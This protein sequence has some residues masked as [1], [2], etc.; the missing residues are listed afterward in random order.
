MVV[1][2]EICSSRKNI[3]D[4]LKLRDYDVDKYSNFTVNE[5]EIL[6]ENEQLDIEACQIKNPTQKVIVKYLWKQTKIKTPS[7]VKEI[8][9]VIENNNITDKNKSEYEIIIVSKDKKSESLQKVL[10]E[11]NSKYYIQYFW[12]KT[13]MYNI[14]EHEFVPKHRI[15][16]NEE[17]DAIRKK[18]NIQNN[19]MPII[20]RNDAV[21]QYLG[22]RAGDICEITRQSETCG[23]SLTYRICV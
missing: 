4:M 1:K 2:K 18:Y 10:D 8:N 15:L 19:Q 6:M 23:D 16:N 7:L 12:I 9:A 21:A 14:M 22:M 13:L 3:I 11:Y 20:H 17:K 5:L